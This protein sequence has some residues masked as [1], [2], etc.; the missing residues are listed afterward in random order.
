MKYL[1]ILSIIS[2]LTVPPVSAVEPPAVQAQ[3][4]QK[5]K[6]KLAK[7]KDHTKVEKP[8]KKSKK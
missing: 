6:L 3:P 4:V 2:F 5:G 7:K 1:V 8:S